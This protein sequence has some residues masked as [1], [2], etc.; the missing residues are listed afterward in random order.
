MP[1]DETFVRK[2]LDAYNSHSVE[3]FDALMTEDCVLV[4][5]GI[6]APGHEAVKRVLGKVFRAFPDIRYEIRDWFAAGD[7]IA[8]RWYG[9]GTHEGEYLGLQPSGR[10]VGYEGITL[11]ELR[12]GKLAHIWVNADM[13]GLVRQIRAPRPEA[14]PSP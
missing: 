3:K 11:Y 13:L 1:I 8:L 4:R 10:E 7:K 6:E 9:H 2:V 12:D 5:N 14:Q